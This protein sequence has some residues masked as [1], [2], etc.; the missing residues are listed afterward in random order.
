MKTALLLRSTC[1]AA[2]LTAGAAFPAFAATDASTAPVTSP[3]APGMPGGPETP[4]GGV[5]TG[6]GTISTE[7]TES[8]KQ[9]VS[10]TALTAKIKAE[11]L[12]TRGLKST[13]IHVK[14]QDGAVTLSGKVPSEDQHSLALKAV[15][16]VDGV[17]SVSDEL[18]VA[19]R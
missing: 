2:A 13:G 15:R 5:R 6:G 9:K 3:T 17:T 14:T 11:L 10:D 18:E 7:G 1:L 19:T 12:A 4:R 8:A 16:G